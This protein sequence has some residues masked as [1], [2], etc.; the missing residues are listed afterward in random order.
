MN[1]NTIHISLK[2][3]QEYYSEFGEF[4]KLIS[5]HTRF[6]NLGYQSSIQKISHPLQ[7]QQA[8][9]LQ[10]A[11][12]GDFK[13]NQT[14]L[15]VGSG[16]GGPAMLIANKYKCHVVGIDI[17]KHHIDDASKWVNS[18]YVEIR[19]G[20]SQDMP[21]E[22]STFDRIYSVES[23]FHYNDKRQ[24]IYES[25]R[26]LKNGGKFVLADILKN[27]NTK[28][29]WLTRTVQRGIGA[30]NLFDV[31]LYRSVATEAGLKLHHVQNITKNVKGVLPI[32]LTFCLKKTGLLYNH[33]GL[34]AIGINIA[35]LTGLYLI[36][37]HPAISY[38]ILVF[39]KS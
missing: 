28:D 21:F 7:A 10:V 17:N 31:D 23:A 30:P 37:T 5:G 35:F 25:G 12:L 16:L 4:F 34:K 9:V 26:V 15:D 3:T 38:E 29:T 20:N 19:Y 39:H 14:I 22:N 27:H 6:L 2:K 11:K 13:D 33:F 1:Q 18:Q 36:C 8:M 24:F 32:W